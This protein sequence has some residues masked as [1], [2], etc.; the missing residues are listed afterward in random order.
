M[1][2]EVILGESYSCVVDYWAVAV[3][4][5]EFVYSFLPFGHNALDVMS[6]CK[7]ITNTN[8]VMPEHLPQFKNFNHLIK[9][10]LRR[11]ASQRITDST[12]IRKHSAFEK[13]SFVN[14]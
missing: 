1:A 6:I 2:P 7:E 13:T 11:N 9:N 8:L 12:V 14:D 10:M 3:L 4:M 5:F